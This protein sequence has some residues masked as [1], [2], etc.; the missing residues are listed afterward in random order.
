ML[1]QIAAE[2]NPLAPDARLAAATLAVNSCARLAGSFGGLG[3]QGAEAYRVCCSATLLFSA[4]LTALGAAAAALQGRSRAARRADLQLIGSLAM[5]A[6]STAY[7]IGAVMQTA[8]GAHDSRL[9]QA[10]LRGVAKPDAVC[11][12]LAAQAA[13]IR[14]F[15]QRQ[16]QRFSGAH[17]V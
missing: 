10:F 17:A 14:V 9:V 2:G 12:W 13:L 8:G 7:N 5:E 16:G 3:L 1:K 11:R 6:A 15:R 4:G